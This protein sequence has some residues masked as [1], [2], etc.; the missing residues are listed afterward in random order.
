MQ[1][2]SKRRVKFECGKDR[3]GCTAKEQEE[4][5]VGGEV[6]SEGSDGPGV[7]ADVA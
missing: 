6:P 2:G 3:H 5:S 4:G 7:L 1:Q